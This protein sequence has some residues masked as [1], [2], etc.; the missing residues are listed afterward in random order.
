MFFKQKNVR[1]K[2][3]A[4]IVI[5]TIF[6]VK[7]NSK[8]TVPFLVG[9]YSFMVFWQFCHTILLI[10]QIM[11]AQKAG[12]KFKRGHHPNQVGIILTLK[13]KNMNWT[14]V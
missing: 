3:R 11:N 2:K 8:K 9:R 6:L 4:I 1:C 7:M 13:Q 5:N 10:S 12:I 14:K